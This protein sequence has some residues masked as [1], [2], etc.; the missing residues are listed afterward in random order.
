MR[1]AKSGE[2]AGSKCWQQPGRKKASSRRGHGGVW[3]VERAGTTR[4]VQPQRTGAEPGGGREKRSRPQ[5]ARSGLS[6]GR[7]PLRDSARG[8][9]RK[10]RRAASPGG[11]EG[12]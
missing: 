1:R 4:E 5:R 2:D 7:R 3:G 8:P 12:S 10:R 6:G 9:R 11:E